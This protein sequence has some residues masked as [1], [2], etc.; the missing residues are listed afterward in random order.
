MHDKRSA[1]K[2]GPI[3]LDIKEILVEAVKAVLA[4]GG[5]AGVGLGMFAILAPPAKAHDAPSGWKYDAYCCNGNNHNGDC[6]PIPSSSVKV[7]SG[8]Y[9]VKIE[10]GQHRLATRA[11]TF[12]FPQTKV[13]RSQDGD[14]H[15][16]LYPDENTPRCFYAPDMSF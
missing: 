10:P 14:Y 6:Q 12:E 3:V 11:H 7:I 13:R 9:S 15:L 5:A 16:C 2:F 4:I 1:N 8:G